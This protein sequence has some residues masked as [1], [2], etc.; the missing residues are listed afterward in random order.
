MNQQFYYSPAPVEKQ[1]VA[2]N[3]AETVAIA[4]CWH[5]T[6]PLFC[7]IKRCY[8]YCGFINQMNIQVIASTGACR[9]QQNLSANDVVPWRSMLAPGAPRQK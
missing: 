9:L 2:I 1:G 3:N 8:Y 4:P 5:I 6:K 7:I